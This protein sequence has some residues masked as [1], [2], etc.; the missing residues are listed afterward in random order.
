MS[1]SRSAHVRPRALHHKGRGTGHGTLAGCRGDVDTRGDGP[2]AARRHDGV[3][4]RHDQAARGRNLLA[5]LAQAGYL[6]LFAGIEIYITILAYG[7]G[8]DYCLFLMARCREELDAGRA[9]TEA[10]C[11]AL[12]VSS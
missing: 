4:L 7:A 10:A 11:D 2:R 6:T 3:Q 5:L 9:P 8:V 1:F 12:M